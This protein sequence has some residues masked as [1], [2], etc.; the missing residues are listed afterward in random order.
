MAEP[1]INAFLTR[2]AVR[3]SVSASTQNQALAALPFLYLTAL[4]RKVS[5]LGDVVRS[6]KQTRLPVVMSR[7]ESRTVL[8]NSRQSRR[9]TNVTCRKGGAVSGCPARWTGNTRMPPGIGP[10]RRYS[11]QEHRWENP[12]TKERGRHHVDP[13]LVRR[14]L[15]DAVLKAGPAKHITCHTFRHSFAPHLLE[16]GHDIR[17]I[18]EIL[19]HSDVKTTMIY[20]HIL[21]RGPGGVRINQDGQHLRLR[22]QTLP[23]TTRQD[24]RGRYA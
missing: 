11:P 14:S 1:E 6:R 9:F 13:S 18:H 16:D 24:R 12:E 2:L 17:T 5:D 15:R 19:G 8:A 22:P 23:G 4:G 10:G 7:D 21:N 20:T 3:E